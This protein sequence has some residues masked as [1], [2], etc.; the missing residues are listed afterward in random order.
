MR[1]SLFRVVVLVFLALSSSAWA[2]GGTDEALVVGYV[3][4]PPFTYTDERGKAAGYLNEITREV[5]ARTGQEL[6]FI[7]VPPARLER[8]LRTGD[9]DV[10]Q[11]IR[12][13]AEQSDRMVA[14]DSLLLPITLAVYQR[15]GAEPFKSVE[16][17]VG[18]RV[19]VLRGYAYGGLIDKLR[20]NS[21]VS[22]MTVNTR[23]SAYRVLIGDRVD[24]FLDYVHPA[25]EALAELG[26]PTLQHTPIRTLDTYWTISNV[27]GDA[28]RILERFEGAYA[29][30]KEEGELVTSFSSE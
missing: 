3:D 15:P 14:G 8:G 25:S 9:V 13:F 30:L 17:F 23:D 10:F 21:D 20:D 4:F 5:A 18:K 2:N 12:I 11:G 28:R 29:E 27:D 6:E 24:F 1:H 26:S 16:D 19:G 22:L 7:E